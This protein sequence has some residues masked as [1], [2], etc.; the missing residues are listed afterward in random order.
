MAKD[1]K[2]STKKGL[3]ILIIFSALFVAG[4]PAIPLGFANGLAWLGVIGIVFVAGGFFGLPIGW[5]FLGEKRRQQTIVSAVVEDGLTDVKELAA[6]FGKSE[7]AMR[8]D[9]VMIFNKRYITGYKFNADKTALIPF[10]KAEIKKNN[11]RKCEF[12]GA[13]L[14]G[15]VEEKCPYCGS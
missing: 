12:C 8:G 11:G 2:K 6:N 9:L 1:L 10:E 5:T 3:L 15:K 4:I 13:V 7:K 14:T